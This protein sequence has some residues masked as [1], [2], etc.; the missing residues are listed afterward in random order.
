MEE[1]EFEPPVLGSRVPELGCYVASQRRAGQVFPLVFTPGSP[2]ITTFFGTLLP[3]C[4]GKPFKPPSAPSPIDHLHTV[5]KTL[6]S[7]CPAFSA[8]NLNFRLFPE[9]LPREGAEKTL[10]VEAG[11]PKS[12]GLTQRPLNPMY[13]TPWGSP[14]SWR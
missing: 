7:L 12:G 14:G 13:L 8:Q 2:P 10:K 11:Q 5:C 9:P 6:K 4:K 3:L 1:W